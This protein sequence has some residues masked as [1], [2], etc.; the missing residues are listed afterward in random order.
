MRWE[1]KTDGQTERKYLLLIPTNTKNILS[2]APSIE[3][4]WTKEKGTWFRDNAT[5]YWEWKSHFSLMSKWERELK[6]HQ[7]ARDQSKPLV[8]IQHGSSHIPRFPAQQH[9]SNWQHVTVLIMT[10]H[11]HTHTLTCTPFK[12]LGT[13]SSFKCVLCSQKLHFW[14]KNTVK[15]VI[16]WYY[17]LKSVLYFNIF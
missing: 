5:T 13:V 12:C 11:T 1:S 4:M 2:S 3:V 6:K 9:L 15:A 10:T 16:L 14:I 17:N 7:S 8:M